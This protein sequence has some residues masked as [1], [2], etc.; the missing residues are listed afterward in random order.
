MAYD[1]R[2]LVDAALELMKTVPARPLAR[3]ASLCGVSRHTLARAFASHAKLSCH[4]ARHRCI[5]S[6]MDALMRDVPPKSIKE[7][8]VGL[9]FATSRS[10]A[11]WLKREDGVVPHERR[12][13]LSCRLAPETREA[14]EECAEDR[15]VYP[16][17]APMT[18]LG[19]TGA[20]PHG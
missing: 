10:F 12:Q 20:A 18:R 15:P 8:S 19:R 3:V 2:L 13:E 4:D 5:R 14:D 16:R 17:A 1:S 11:R 7:I 9:G 6:R